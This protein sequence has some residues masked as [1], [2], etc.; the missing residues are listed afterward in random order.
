MP[1]RWNSFPGAFPMGREFRFALMNR[2]AF[3]VSWGRWLVAVALA[4]FSSI[5]Q[6]SAAAEASPTA[7]NT[8][9]A[10]LEVLVADVAEHNPEL[11]FYRAEIAAANGEHRTS[12]T[13][14]NPE[15]STTVG[16]KRVT[17]GGLS[18]EGVAWSVSVRQ[19]FEWPGRISLRK[20]IA[21]HQVQLAELGFAQ[22][23]SSLAAR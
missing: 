5:P 21:N 1:H 4:G 23:K 20:A 22:F 10:A 19:T 12:A 14:V 17:A 11:N 7:T 15:L 13:W 9:S 6:L 18:D 2:I 16:Q 3:E 8:Q